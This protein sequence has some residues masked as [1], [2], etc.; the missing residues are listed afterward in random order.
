MPKCLSALSERCS[1][2]KQNPGALGDTRILCSSS[3][4]CSDGAHAEPEILSRS[5]PKGV[6]S[7]TIRW[8]GVLVKKA[9]GLTT[10]NPFN[11]LTGDNLD[12]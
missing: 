10:T 1:G 2:G 3:E 9:I 7:F 11:R 4:R 12:N 8:S 5:Y 6:Q